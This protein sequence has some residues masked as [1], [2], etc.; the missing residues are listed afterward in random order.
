M[1]DSP[2]M[3]S[4][5]LFMSFAIDKILLRDPNPGEPLPSLP[6]EG[7]FSHMLYVKKEKKEATDNKA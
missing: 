6:G 5:R 7:F 4:L 2:V 3:G 1:P